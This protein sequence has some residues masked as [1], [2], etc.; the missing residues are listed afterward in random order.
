MALSLVDKFG[1][2]SKNLQTERE[3]KITVTE[4]DI[5]DLA[6]EISEITYKLT[7]KMPL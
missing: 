4:L 5:L 3:M 7:D 1:I 6:I 2:A